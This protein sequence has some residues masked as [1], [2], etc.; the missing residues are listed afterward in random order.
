MYPGVPRRSSIARVVLP[1]YIARVVLPVYR[2]IPPPSWCIGE[3]P[4]S[5][6]VYMAFLIVSLVY[7]AS[8]IASLVYMHGY[9]SLVYMHG[10]Y[11]LVYMRY[12]CA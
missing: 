8:L 1:V 12:L 9:Y 4:S 3:Y 5:L 2:S 7:M 10:Y 6:L 11:S